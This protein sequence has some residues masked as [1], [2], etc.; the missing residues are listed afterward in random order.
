[1]EL[2]AG[3]AHVEPGIGR[4]LKAGWDFPQGIVGVVVGFWALERRVMIWEAWL[5]EGDPV[6]R[7]NAGQDGGAKSLDRKGQAD[8]RTPR[9]CCCCGC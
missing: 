9:S 5:D 1:M 6:C 4:L 3:A 7:I 2:V 8:E